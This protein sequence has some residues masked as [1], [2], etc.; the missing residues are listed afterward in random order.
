MCRLEKIKNERDEQK[1]KNTLKDVQLA[2]INNINLL[3][4]I[5]TAVKEYATL[6][7]ISDCL[8]SVFGE[9]SI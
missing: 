2:A 8:R 4:P 9:Y 7:E 5:I 6:G 1:V 3:I